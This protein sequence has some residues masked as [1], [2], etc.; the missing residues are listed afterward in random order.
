MLNPL[1]LANLDLPRS[2]IAT[3]LIVALL[4][5]VGMLTI[6]PPSGGWEQGLMI[7]P[8]LTGLVAVIL[9]IGTRRSVAQARQEAGAATTTDAVTGLAT[10][11]TG[12]EVLRMEFAKVQREPERALTI[13]LIRIEELERYRA[14]H[15]DAVTERLLRESGL[16][17]SK[18]RRGMHMT[19]RSAKEPATFI[20][21]LSGVDRNGATVYATRLRRDLLQIRALPRPVGISVGI[22]AYDMTMASPKDLV[23]KAAFALKKGAAAGGKVVVVGGSEAA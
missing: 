2:A 20:A 15:G 11:Q 8:V 23:R 18:H 13:A 14:R 5:A 6:V 3:Y 10:A 21:I 19:A 17:M 1:N 4:A 16:V 9:L 22:A 12:E 7:A